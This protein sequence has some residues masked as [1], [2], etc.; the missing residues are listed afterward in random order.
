MV[1]IKL[2]IAP[3]SNPDLGRRLISIPRKPKAR[4][5]ALVGVAMDM[6]QFFNA[7][8]VVSWILADEISNDP[9]LTSTV[10]DLLKVFEKLAN[11]PGSLKEYDKAA[12]VIGYYNAAK[13]AERHNNRYVGEHV[14]IYW[15]DDSSGQKLSGI[16]LKFDSDYTTVYITDPPDNTNFNPRPISNKN[17]HS[18][19]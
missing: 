17:V 1:T 5:H 12:A 4:S 7:Q 14:E 8:T 10:A 13:A 11:T 6:I 18:E 19:E 3:V 15:D 2:T 16:V 9:I